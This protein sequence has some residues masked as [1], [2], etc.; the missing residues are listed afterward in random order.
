MEE[1]RDLFGF[2]IRE[3]INNRKSQKMEGMEE[4]KKE[5]LQIRDILYIASK[6]YKKGHKQP[7]YET[8]YCN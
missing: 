1:I 2:Q 6:K 5:N 3:A 8:I 4:I 7:T